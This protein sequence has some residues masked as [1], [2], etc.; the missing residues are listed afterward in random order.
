MTWGVQWRSANRLDGVT[1]RLVY[2]G[3]VPALFSTRREAREWTNEIYGYIRSR[4]DLRSEP[5]GWRVPKAVKIDVV[6]AS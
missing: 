1:E 2:R 5:H 3:R 4:Q 6:V